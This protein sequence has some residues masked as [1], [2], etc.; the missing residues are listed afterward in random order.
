[1]S[2]RVTM[3]DLLAGLLLI[4]PTMAS[5]QTSPTGTVVG[6]VRD[7]QTGEPLVFA[8]VMVE[9]TTAG[10]VTDR[11]G[12]YRLPGLRPGE[13]HI[14]AAFMGYREGHRVI[15]VRSGKI[16]SLDFALEPTVMEMGTVV[17]TGTATPHL[18]EDAPVRTEV[19]PRLI[20]E[21]K[22]APNLAEALSFHT[23]VRVE[24]NC[25]NCNFTQVRI[26]GMQGRYSQILIDGDPV[27]SSLAGVYGLEHI[28]EEM[29]DQIEIVK[30]GGSALYGAGAVAGVVN[31]ITRRP[32]TNR[33]RVRYRHHSTGGIPDSH[34]SALAETV[35]GS[36][37][38]GAYIFGSTRRRSPYDHNRDGYSELG[39]LQNE[40]AGFKFYYQPGEE[41][42]LLAS[43]HHI[44]EERR[45]GNKFT[46]PVHEADIAEWTEHRRTGGSVRWTQRTGPAFDYR[47]FY[48]FSITDRRSYYGGLEG[49]TPQD[50][51][52][53]L[54]YY[55]N[56]DDPLHIGGFQANYQGGAHLLTFGS[57][58]SY[59]GLTDRTA[60]ETAY[61]VDEAYTNVGIFAQDNLHLGPEEEVEFVF[62]VRLDRHSQLSDWIVSPR[63]NGKFILGGG[64][65]L[66]AACSTGFKPPQI[67][68]EDLHLCGLEGDQRVI[69]NAADLREERSTTLSTG[70]EYMGRLE[71]MPAMVS[72]TLFRTRMD[73]S[74]TEVFVASQGDIEFWER[75]NSEG[76]GVAGAEIDAGIRPSSAI[77]LRG[78][79]TYV[80][81]RYDAPH[82]DFG[83]RRFLRTPEFTANLQLDAHLSSRLELFLGG[84]FTG[85]ADVPHEIV[86]EGQ[87]DPE[88]RLERSSEF[89]QID[90][91]LSWL[92]PLTDE[93]ETTLSLGVKNLM[94]SYQED[95]DRGRS[96]DPAYIYG[97]A[98]PRTYYAAFGSSF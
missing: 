79:C 7:A 63:L 29:I 42:E 65:L 21:R 92:L 27:V 73:D 75:R 24:N 6:H 38:S 39:S 14:V 28:P 52:D 60:S 18:V 49:D 57:R 68:S 96:R 19:I 47:L 59:D 58:Y 40:S 5:G 72:L 93:L 25:Q 55:G 56:S 4:W 66:R 46:L 62:G 11:S 45:G 32:M 48:S 26:L 78:G 10:T 34:M 33:V 64:F 70:L 15:R 31:V 36:G 88:L 91:G 71:G 37:T 85:R 8:N 89:I 97:P 41:E 20:I 12:A 84:S 83:T 69:R 82:E 43:F 87:E 16:D 51:L 17:V 53:A 22:Q 94:D 30:G 2:S 50:R 90:A 54:A 23:G 1:M 13:T 3:R 67:Y 86:V 35:N 81:G 9:H 77:E 74:F 95:L 76:S 44:H 98:R 61:Y 80:R